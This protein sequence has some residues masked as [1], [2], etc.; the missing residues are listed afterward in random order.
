MWCSGQSDGLEWRRPGF[1][2]AQPWKLTR[3][4]EL[5]KP[6]LKYLIYLDIPI[7]FQLDGIASAIEYKGI[8]VQVNMHRIGILIFI[9]VYYRLFVFI[10]S[11]S[12]IFM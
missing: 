10:I 7:Q 6:L 9:Q 3:G 5:V 12:Q 8:N 2:S 4:V 11:V 1:E